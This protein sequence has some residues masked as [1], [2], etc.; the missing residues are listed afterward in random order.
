MTALVSANEITKVPTRKA[1]EPGLLTKPYQ[2][3]V[4]ADL[5]YSETTDRREVTIVLN[6]F[7]PPGKNAQ[8][9][10]NSVPLLAYSE[11]GEDYSNAHAYRSSLPSEEELSSLETY[12][13]YVAV[14]GQP[15]DSPRDFLSRGG[16]SFDT[17][18]WRL[19]EPDEGVDVNILHVTMRRKWRTNDASNNTEQNELTYEIERV[20][21]RS[22]NFQPNLM[23]T[24]SPRSSF[25]LPGLLRQG[26][27]IVPSAL[28]V[29][30][31]N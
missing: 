26:P 3:T 6:Y 19:F 2:G 16:Y 4:M 17:V 20:R 5:E 7:I 18:V 23:Q 25:I 12:A 10:P 28:P 24:R 14:L 1:G 8:G 31:S 11:D 21:I 13:D 27:S 15:I 22:G 30:S 9:P 29:V